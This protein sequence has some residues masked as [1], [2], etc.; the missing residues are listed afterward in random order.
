MLA[1]AWP[2]AGSSFKLRKTAGK[3]SF[4]GW[5][6]EVSTRDIVHPAVRA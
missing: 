3:L 4:H 6:F 1:E 5:N 2:G